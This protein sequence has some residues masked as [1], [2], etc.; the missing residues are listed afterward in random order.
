[1]QLKQLAAQLRQVLALS[2]EK[3]PLVVH[4]TV[5]LLNELPQEVH[6]EMDEP[7]VEVVP[8]GHFVHLVFPTELL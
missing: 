1:M 4:P 6:V 5:Q 7:A 2:L 8:N 3:Y